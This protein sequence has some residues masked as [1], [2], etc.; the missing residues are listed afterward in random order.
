[1]SE[2]AYQ[3]EYI[4]L[5]HG[6]YRSVLPSLND[7]DFDCVLLDPPFETWETVT[8]GHFQ[9]IPKKVVFTNWQ[10]RGVIESYFGK[11]RS[12]FVWYFKDGRWV[13]HRLPR[14]T[15]ELIY[16]YGET[17]EAYVGEKIED[18]TPQNKGRGAVGKDTYSTHIY[19]PRERKILNSVLEYPRNNRNGMGAWGKPEKLIRNLLEFVSPGVVLDPFAG[20]GSTLT[21][22]K[23]LKMKAIGIEIDE[24]R[25]ELIISRLAD[26]V[27]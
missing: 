11:P 2:L 14:Q 1:M 8:P 27:G 15:H 16:I 4:K 24:K 18:R 17:V 6:D 5:F 26:G 9:G 12:E 20:G 10:H 13:S 7:V 3:D 25:C 21:V 22:A 23:K 19:R